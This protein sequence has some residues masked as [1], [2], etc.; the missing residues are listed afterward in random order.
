MENIYEPTIV[1][2]TKIIQQSP[3]VKSF[4][5][6]PVG[7]FGSFPKNKN[8]VVFNPGQFLL[9]GNIGWGESAF[10]PMSSPYEDKYME[11]MVRNAGKVT[12]YLHSLK[13]G[14]KITI[15]GPF[16][17]GFPAD[18]FKG[19]D[20]MAVTGGCGIPPIS[21]TIEYIIKHRKDYKNV[22]VIYGAKTPD[23]ILIKDRLEEWKKHNID[24][25][26]TIDKP[27]PDWS[28][29]VGFVTDLVK[30]VKIDEKNAVAA[31]CGPGPM[32]S[33][34]EKIIRP[35]GI[36]DRNIFVNMERKMQ[37]GVGKCQHCTCGK[38]YVCTDGPVFNFDD[39]DKN[40]D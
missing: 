35:L 8:K 5:L 33:A 16:G 37:C 4:R 7:L 20:V 11:I 22:H 26:V 39:I 2:I 23:E 21:A 3:T 28:G 29:P 38:K 9:V 18:Y 13:E 12:G 27:A 24:V 40:H 15:R 31:M 17:N 25:V 1:K 19:K 10:G 14:D 32:M 6:E 34:I 30:H 36:S